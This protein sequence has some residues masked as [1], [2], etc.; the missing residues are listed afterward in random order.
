VGYAVYS[1]EEI[2]KS[3]KHL[4]LEQEWGS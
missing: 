1:V 3:H 4:S 2:Q